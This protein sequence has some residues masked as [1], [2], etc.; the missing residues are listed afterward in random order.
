EA[1]GPAALPALGAGLHREPPAA[2]AA[3][4]EALNRMNLADGVPILIEAAHDPTPEVRQ[5]AILGL[6]HIGDPRGR[7]VVEAARDG[8][9]SSVRLAAAHASRAPGL[10]T[11]PRAIARLV[12]IAIHDDIPNSLWARV[13]L[14]RI[15][16]R[17][18]EPAQEARADIERIAIPAVQAG[19]LD[20]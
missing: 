19:S 7:P 17:G 6:G 4:C 16:G 2:R 3:I 8:P 20:E 1:L 5:Q 14:I 15:M 13:A 11:S 12:D 9:N 18:G 10:C